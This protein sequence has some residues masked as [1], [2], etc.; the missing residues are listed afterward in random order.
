MAAQAPRLKLP[1]PLILDAA[2]ASDRDY[3]TIARLLIFRRPPQLICELAGSSMLGW[4]HPH[5]VDQRAVPLKERGMLVVKIIRLS[6]I[7]STS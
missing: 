5:R 4:P 7:Y 2:P 3:R 6:L 1:S